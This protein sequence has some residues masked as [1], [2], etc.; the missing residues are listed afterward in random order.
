MEDSGVE[1]LV[2]SV[3]NKMV[4]SVDRVDWEEAGRNFEWA[5]LLR[6]ASGRAVQKQP[7]ENILSKIR[8]IS[9]PATFL[10]VDR[11]TLL[12]IFKTLEDH[13]RVLNGVTWSYEGNAVLLQKWKSRMTDDDFENTKINIWVQVRRLPFEFRVTNMQRVLQDMQVKSLK[14]LSL[15]IPE[16]RNIVGN[17]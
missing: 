9:N 7:F 8:R 13:D 15:E 12:V 11:S 16:M 10:K 4:V 6:L 2:F 14:R 1:T 17:L 3:R 5:I